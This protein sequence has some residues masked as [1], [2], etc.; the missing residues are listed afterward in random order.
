MWKQNGSQL[1]LLLLNARDTKVLF[2]DAFICV[3]KPRWNSKLRETIGSVISFHYYNCRLQSNGVCLSH[4]CFENMVV[5]FDR[6]KQHCWVM[7]EEN[8]ELAQIQ[9]DCNF[10]SN[11]SLLRKYVYLSNCFEKLRRTIWLAGPE[12]ARIFNVQHD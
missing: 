9:I 3:S 10:S 7:R 2:C 6:L 12:S 8:L 1:L 5:Y 4:V 11:L